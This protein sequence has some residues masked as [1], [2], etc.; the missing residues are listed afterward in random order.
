MEDLKWYKLSSD[1]FWQ[2]KFNNVSIGDF[3]ITPAVSLMMA[4]TGTSLNMIPSEDFDKIV[5]DFLKPK[6]K[7]CHVMASSLTACDCSEEQHMAVPDIKFQI[8]GDEYLIPRESWFERVASSQKCVVKFMHGPGQDYW[9][10]GLNFFSSYYTV[11][12]YENMQIG[13][14]KSTMYGHPVP[15]GFIQETAAQGLSQLR[16]IITNFGQLEFENI[17]PQNKILIGTGTIAWALFGAYYLIIRKS[18][19]QLNES[20]SRVEDEVETIDESMQYEGLQSQL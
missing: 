10:L 20:L 18:K 7:N 6:F 5:N 4:D 19:K 12:D 3:K 14:A 1:E 11:F 9:I 16:Q 8:N 17:T 15:L 2:F 13:F